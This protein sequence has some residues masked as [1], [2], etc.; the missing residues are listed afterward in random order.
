[1]KM[2]TEQEQFDE[3]VWYVLNQI[4]VSKRLGSTFSKVNGIPYVTSAGKN[5]VPLTDIDEV[6]VLNYLVEKGIISIV[7]K[8]DVMEV[9]E[10]WEEKTRFAGF[11]YTLK[12]LEKFDDFFKT[13]QIKFG[14]ETNLYRLIISQETG[15]II[16]VT[17]KDFY[18]TIFRKHDMAY[19]LLFMM[20]QN[21]HKTFSSSELCKKLDEE[22]SNTHKNVD[23]ERRIRDLLKFIRQKLK[24]KEKKDDNKLFIV[25]NKNFGI[26]CDI[27][28]K[29]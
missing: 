15:E 25:D 16:Y 22:K 14:L 29:K 13:Y 27:E 4:K 23:D 12:L 8:Q 17:P 18:K 3:N 28:I 10:E 2:K 1:M 19:R 9:R 20:A 24:L 21:P 6:V 5:N 11:T 26:N 7:G